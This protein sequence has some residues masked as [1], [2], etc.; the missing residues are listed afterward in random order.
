MKFNKNL[1][2]LLCGLLCLCLCLSACKKE[3]AT[4]TTPGQENPKDA[5]YTITLKTAG[6]MVL[7]N[8]GVYVYEDDTEDDLLT[9]GTLDDDGTFT[10]TATESDKYTV[11]FAN[12][13][14]EGYDVQDYYPITSTNTNITLTSSVITGKDALEEGKTYAL[15]DVMRDFTVTTV[16]GE[17][18]TLSEILE[19]KQA[20]VLN[21]WYTG[22]NPCKNEFP[23]L[24]AAYEAYSDKLEVI[25]MN[26]IDISRD[27]VDS[28][29]AYRD[30]NGLTMP[31]ATCSSQWF[32]ALGIKSYPTTVVID[33]YGVICLI[34]GTVEEEGVFEGA[35]AHFTAEDY[36]QKLVQDISE[37]YNVEY[38]E[39]H[40]KN[41]YQTHGAVGQ[42]AVTVPAESEYYVLIYKADG[43]T[44]RIE[45]PNAYVIY[46]DVRYEPNASGVIEVVI[47]NPD[48][49]VGASLVIGNTDAADST[50]QVEVMI[51]Q[52]TSST[53]YEGSLG[54]VTVNIPAG[55]DQGVYYSWTAT[56]DGLLTLTVTGAPQTDYDVQLYNTVTMAVRNLNEEV[57]V[58][59]NGNPYVSVEVRAGD[60]VRIGYMSMP[61]ASGNYPAATICAELSFTEIEELETEY[62]VTVVDE[63]GNLM[64]DVAI[65]VVI[66]GVE[67]QFYSNAEGQ[68]LMELPSGTYT[69]KVM[70]PEGYTCDTTQFLLTATNPTKEVV[71]KAYVPQEVPYTVYVV[72]ETGAPVAN[73]AVVLDGSF[74]Y[75]DENGMVSVILLESTS[76]VATVVAPEGY[77]IENGNVAFGT[78]TTITVV[79]YRQTE[80]LKKVDY[81]VTVVDQNGDPVTNVLVRFDSEDGSV[82]VTE[83]VNASG[84]VVVNLPETNYN[85]TIVFNGSSTMGYEPTT[86]KLTPN[87]T[88]LTVELVPYLDSATEELYTGDVAYN[89]EPG[90]FYVDLTD[91]DI[92][93]FV[94]TPTETGIYTFTT[95]NSSAAVGYWGSP[96][97]IFGASS[98][99][100]IVNNVFTMEVK[101][102]G[103]TY[104]LSVS[105][106]EGVTGTVLKI[107][108]TGDPKPDPVYVT[109]D[110]TTEPTEP[111]VVEETGSKT[112]LDLSVSHTLVK[113]SDGYYHYGSADG[114]IVYMDLTGVRFGISIAEVID[115]SALYKYEYDSNGN[116]VKRTDYTECM[117]SYVQNVDE[118]HGVY[119]LTDDLITI[120]QEHGNHAG[121]YDS[122]SVNYLFDGENVLA[123][124]AWMFLLCTFQ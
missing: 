37:L 93:Y 27:S 8:V 58:D 64:A 5:I 35:F 95:T 115:R 15:G 94:F 14:E 116:P 121:W 60:E 18:L 28:I 81:T 99:E 77:T 119:A 109:Y 54:E 2:R 16:D 120:L 46:N 39:G 12:L 65:S 36:Q 96:S 42:F 82:S 38:E 3:T 10:F 79:V 113:G 50:I 48:V 51:P 45:E 72:D 92:R 52:G 68:I 100:N 44:L 11:R 97:F 49:M 124:S 69:V 98:D 108:R 41:P 19:E 123:E 4:T 106:G 114:D 88:T 7:K 74:Y 112:Y 78:E 9:Y 118:T 83:A 43:V 110:G 101:S 84:I 63:S 76:Y 105:G 57:R 91:M 47:D 29:I 53:P 73:A 23:L 104:V 1:A 117:Y 21:F 33:R 40:P 71:L 55:N 24:Q 70:V 56:A 30:A 61:D 86:A 25:T 89:L 20:V 111:F 59:E 66:D 32:S 31:M 62:C 122:E 26:P 75:T 17:E 80:T 22:C 102:V 67:V 6:G 13:P 85:V 103:Q 107:T 87:K 90:S 34:T